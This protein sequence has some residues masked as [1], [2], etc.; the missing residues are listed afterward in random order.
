M[1]P[2]G[3]TK[4]RGE[5]SNQAADK[6]AAKISVC[7]QPKS[8]TP[9]EGDCHLQP[10]STALVLFGLVGCFKRWQNAW[11]LPFDADFDC[12][13]PHLLAAICKSAFESRPYD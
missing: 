5:R 8:F 11:I 2:E 10:L 4:L 13:F 3:G 12:H 9:D 7:A 6:W 1:T